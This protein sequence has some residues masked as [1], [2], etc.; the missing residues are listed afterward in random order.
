MFAT[1]N[2]GRLAVALLRGCCRRLAASSVIQAM[3][4]RPPLSLVGRTIRVPLR[5]RFPRALL[6][7]CLAPLA[8]VC[9]RVRPTGVTDA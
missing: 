1:Q 6:P 5:P 3:R 8:E 2:L 4:V 7:P 9:L